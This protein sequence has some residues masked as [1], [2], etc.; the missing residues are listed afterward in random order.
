V[1]DLRPV[2]PHTRAAVL[3]HQ[4]KAELPQTLQIVCIEENMST[5]ERLTLAT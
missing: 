3:D 1:P 2:V 5:S 4:N